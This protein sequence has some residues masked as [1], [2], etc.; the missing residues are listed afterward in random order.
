MAYGLQDSELLKLVGNEL[1]RQGKG[2]RS[3]IFCGSWCWGQCA[4]LKDRVYHSFT[5]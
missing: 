2:N 3:G 5:L 1:E 4:I